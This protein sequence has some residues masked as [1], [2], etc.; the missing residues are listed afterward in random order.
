[1]GMKDIV[2]I[3]WNSRELVNKI[4]LTC[5]NDYDHGIDWRW[6]AKMPTISPS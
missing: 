2:Q 3:F 1:M 5:R 4:W 6:L